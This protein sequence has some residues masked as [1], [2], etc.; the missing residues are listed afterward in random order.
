[1]RRNAIYF[2]LYNANDLAKRTNYS[3]FA[4][5]NTIRIYLIGANNGCNKVYKAI[6]TKQ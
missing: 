6:A 1:V 3:H 5:L 2:R 4:V